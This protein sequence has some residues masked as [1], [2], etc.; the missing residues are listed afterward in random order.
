MSRGRRHRAEHV[1]WLD[2]PPVPVS[3]SSAFAY[4]SC[5]Q[6]EHGKAIY[7]LAWNSCDPANA[8]VFASA[9][10]NYVNVYAC[11]RDGAMDLLQA[12]R[13]ADAEEDFY[14]CTWTLAEA[15][16]TPLLAAAGKRGLVQVIDA[17]HGTLHRSLVGHGGAVN[18]LK[19]HPREPALLL[20]CSRDR[21]L[22][23]W[24]VQSGVLALILA[25]DGGHKNEIVT[26]DWHARERCTLVSG[27]FDHCVKLWRL[28]D[29]AYTA[30]KQAL[31][32]WDPGTPLGRFQTRFVREPVFTTHRVHTNFIDC[33]RFFGDAV[34]SKSV[35]G[36]IALWL[37]ESDPGRPGLVRSLAELPL[38]EA[39][40]TWIRFDL[41]LQRR[42]LACGNVVGEVRVWDLHSHPP[43]L[44][45][46]LA[47]KRVGWPPAKARA[48]AVDDS[49]TV[50]QCCPSP[51][52]RTLLASCNDGSV[53]RWDVRRGH[54]LDAELRRA[55]EGEGEGEGE[56]AMQSD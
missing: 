32:P 10:S 37:P 8:H 54:P 43:L 42:I 5:V 49:L 15:D 31:L 55:Y 39:S 29:A 11:R 18:D 35:D 33:V 38:P 13:D 2:T 22:R 6:E 17:R 1:S 27:G 7:G 21:S 16:G 48:R 12:Y 4:T 20:S 40:L 24:N 52:G 23:L 30:V 50:R 56:E 14:V 28:D 9:T 53:W 45:A 26:C 46:Q 47:C 19:A 41:D 3:P 25:G 34:L 36:M 44:L 51:D